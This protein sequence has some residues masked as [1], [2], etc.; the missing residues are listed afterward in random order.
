MTNKT[1]QRYDRVLRCIQKNPHITARLL[2]V[3][4]PLTPK[5]IQQTLA[6]LSR[7][8]YIQRAAARGHHSYTITTLGVEWLHE[9][10][11][12]NL[13]PER[14]QRL[15]KYRRQAEQLE[16]LGFWHR[17]ARQWLHVLDL[18][19]DDDARIAAVPHRERCIRMLS[20]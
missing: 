7:R 2:R 8:E 20:Q 12:T 1:I 18:S 13:T 9:N 17:A 16:H 3:A 6:L 10:P 5:E 4:L 14:M 11:P 19:P 15:D